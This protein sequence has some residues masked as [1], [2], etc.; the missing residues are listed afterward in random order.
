MGPQTIQLATCDLV[1]GHQHTF[2]G[3]V[4]GG[5]FEPLQDRVFFVAGRA[6]QATDPIALGD[7]GQCLENPSTDVR[8]R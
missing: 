7:V 6:R 1:I 5:F 2:D 8:R 4:L 3:F